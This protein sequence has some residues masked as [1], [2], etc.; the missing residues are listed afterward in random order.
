MRRNG[1][2][3]SRPV[4]PDNLGQPRH[5]QERQVGQA[6]HLGIW[7]NIAL[8]KLLSHLSANPKPS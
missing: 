8:R 2:A 6:D 7:D 3:V 1:P 5:V 4:N